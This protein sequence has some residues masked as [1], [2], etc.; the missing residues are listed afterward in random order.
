MKL[1]IKKSNSICCIMA[2]ATSLGVANAQVNP[3]K[4]IVIQDV[5]A[6]QALQSGVERL[7]CLDAALPALA[8]A[9]PEAAMSLEEIAEAKIRREEQQKAAAEAAFG[10][11][12]K[13][14]EPP[15][16][17][18]ETVVS[19]R[20]AVVVPDELKQLGSKISKI[21]ETTRDRVIVT[22]DNGQVW[23]QTKATSRRISAKK[24][25]GAEAVVTKKRLGNYSMRIQD[26]FNI[27]VERI[28]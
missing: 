24:Y 1:D 16:E 21:K 5:L 28:K 7:S 12:L 6:C 3:K 22:L 19:N 23:L 9:F 15:K 11:T 14:V 17:V 13:D 2:I 20:P 26:N 10:Q 8:S 4:D 18:E 27:D 25:E